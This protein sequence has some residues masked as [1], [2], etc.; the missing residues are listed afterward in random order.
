M[1][2][3]LGFSWSRFAAKKPRKKKGGKKN[4]GKG[5]PK[6]NAWTQYIGKK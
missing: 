3:P 4:T 6:G 5:K 2:T 1:T